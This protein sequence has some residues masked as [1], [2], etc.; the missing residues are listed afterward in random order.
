[1]CGSLCAKFHNGTKV[2]NWNFWILSGIDFFK[3]L[4]LDLT[5]IQNWFQLYIS[6]FSLQQ[7]HRQERLQDRYQ[8]M[9]VSL[10]RTIFAK[11]C[12]SEL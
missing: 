3:F 6:K 10:L 9:L 11:V 4:S 12:N 8:Q 7:D 2:Q 5:Y 1:M